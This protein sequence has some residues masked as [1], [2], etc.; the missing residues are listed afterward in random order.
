MLS[1]FY[2]SFYKN[3]ISC[4][5]IFCS[6]IHALLFR[7]LMWFASFLRQDSWCLFLSSGLVW[8]LTFCK[9]CIDTGLLWEKYTLA[10]S[11]E[12]HKWCSF[13]SS[14]SHFCLISRVWFRFLS[15]EVIFIMSYQLFFTTKY[16][17][18][19]AHK[20]TYL[21]SVAEI[22]NSVI[23]FIFSLVYRNNNNYIYTC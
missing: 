23:F 1:N 3:E 6:W 10:C 11:V 13:C 8:V 4:F 15:K 9:V 20:V 12:K 7:E 2:V 16:H 21:F 22:S 17:F 18:N 5:K 19:Y 14:W